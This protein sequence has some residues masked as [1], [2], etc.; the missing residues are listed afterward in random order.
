MSNAIEIAWTKVITQRMQAVL[1][2][3]G[4]RAVVA[5]LTGTPDGEVPTRLGKLFP[6]AGIIGIV[7]KLGVT[8]QVIREDTADNP[9]TCVG[10]D[11]LTYRLVDATFTV[12]ATPNL[13]DP[14]EITGKLAGLASVIEEITGVDYDRAA[15]LAGQVLAAAHRQPEVR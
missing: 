10:R 4:V 1:P 7:G 6:S 13:N 3:D 15:D 11:R 2:V 12:T 8:P 9:S 5:G 14:V